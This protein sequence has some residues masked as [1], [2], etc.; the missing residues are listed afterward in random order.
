MDGRQKIH[1]FADTD[2]YRGMAEIAQDV[3]FALLPVAGWGPTLGDR[4]MGPQ[5]AAE[6]SNLLAPGCVR[7]KGFCFSQ[8]RDYY[9]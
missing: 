7:A 3:D 8:K 4:P 2:C 6:A 9:L 1:L 5:Q